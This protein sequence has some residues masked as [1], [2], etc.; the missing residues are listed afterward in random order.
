VER[1]PITVED[2][3]DIQAMIRQYRHVLSAARAG[4]Y[5]IQAH[6]GQ[7]DA[8][9]VMHITPSVHQTI[10]EAFYRTAADIQDELRDRYNVEVG[11]DE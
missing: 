7:E 5:T 1:K 6:P 8:F 3:A 11:K 9:S 10:E 2:L 4:H